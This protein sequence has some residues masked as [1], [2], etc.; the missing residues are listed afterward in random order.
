MLHLITGGSGFLGSLIAKQVDQQGERV[1]ILDVWDDAAR[2]PRME[3]AQCDIRNRA[4]VAETMKGVDVVHHNVALV[5]LTKSGRKF[6]DVNVE[7]SRIA[8]EEA[9][10]AGVK[11]F[12][13]MSSSAIFGVPMQCPI[14]NDTPTAP[15]EIYG[16]TKLAGE[17]AVREICDRHKLPLIV[18][19]PRTI[20]G[21]G[22]L[23]IFQILFEW[24]KDGRNAYVIG[25]GNHL[26]QFV[27]ATDLI[28]AYTLVLN[29]G[30]TGVYNV[31]TDRFGTMREALEHL[32]VYAGSSSKVKSLPASLTIGTL[33]RS[34]GCIYL[35][36]RLGTT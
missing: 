35:P 25:S 4:G 30:K 19:R 29:A 7:G 9:V 28:S 20:L 36:W 21:N 26:Y 6:W 22:R 24:I 2:P 27:Q 8:A 23:G 11:C 32:I 1:R 12:V 10:K 17:Q 14:T 18:I 16:R 33:R 15:V 13:H 31:G 5:P 3:Y 34:T